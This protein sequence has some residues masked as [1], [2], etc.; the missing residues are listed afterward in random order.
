MRNL[1]AGLVA[2]AGSMIGG[3]YIVRAL[4]RAI[5]NGFSPGKLGAVHQVGTMQYTGFVIICLI[6]ISLMLVLAFMGARWMGL[7]N[8][9]RP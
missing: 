5:E 4:L 9:D 3:A 6:G 2:I 1:P 7:I 8:R